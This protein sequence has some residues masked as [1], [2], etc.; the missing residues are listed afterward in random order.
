MRHTVTNRLRLARLLGASAATA[1]ATAGMTLA[2]L[3]VAFASQIP[4]VQ[5]PA[6]FQPIPDIWASWDPS[7]ITVLKAINNAHIHAEGIP[8]ITLPSN[9]SSLTPA[10]KLLVIANLERLSRGLPPVLGLN[11]ILDTAAEVGVQH[12]TDPVF[13]TNAPFSFVAWGSNWAAVPGGVLEADYGWMYQDG[14]GGDNID[15]TPTNSTGCFGHRDNIL[16]NWTSA[17]SPLSLVMGAAGTSRTTSTNDFTELFVAVPGATPPTLYFTW[18]QELP[19]FDTQTISL[20]TGQNVSKQLTATNGVGPYTWTV[21][22]TASGGGGSTVGGS[23]AS[24]DAGSGSTSVGDG[25]SLSSGGVLTGTPSQS[26]TFTFQATVTDAR[27]QVVAKPTVTIAVAPALTN[28]ASGSGQGAGSGSGPGV[29]QLISTVV[30][31]SASKATGVDGQS[32]ITLSVPAQAFSAQ[33]QLTVSSVPTTSF[34]SVDPANTTPIAAFDVSVSGSAATHP[35]SLTVSSPVIPANARVYVQAPSGQTSGGSTSGRQTSSGQTSG[36]LTQVPA[37]VQA[38]KVTFGFTA[39]ETVVIAAPIPAAQRLATRNLTWSSRTFELNGV[40][41]FV[42]PGFT[43]GGTYYTSVYDVQQIL[44]RLGLQNVWHVNMLN[45][46]S[47]SFNVS[48]IP[49][50]H[51]GNAFMEVNGRAQMAVPHIVT[52]QPGTSTP[53][54]YIEIWDLQRILNSVGLNANGYNGVQRVWNIVSN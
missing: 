42:V 1:I 51:A 29:R 26:G 53:T 33:D 37:Q 48:Q 3:P 12:S 24:G 47:S 22:S 9:Y 28:T 7:D 30:G 19:Y 5:P 16:S 46:D 39:G 41:Q 32:A 25:L 21:G 27:R 49:T 6:N 40:K 34:I 13:P 2:T 38:G 54:S 20:A 45:I 11:S 36:G 15:C 8:T 23:T 10:E 44:T 18:Q 43:Y 52:T 35:V 17:Y 4:A 50:T 14:Q 31:S